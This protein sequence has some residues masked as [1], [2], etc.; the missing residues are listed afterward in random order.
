METLKNNPTTTFVAV[1]TAITSVWNLAAE[2]AEILG[3]SGKAIAIG[4][5]VLT[6]T[7]MVYNTLK[8]E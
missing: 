2:N 6:A 5:L 1:L 3:I 4:G 8:S 7:M